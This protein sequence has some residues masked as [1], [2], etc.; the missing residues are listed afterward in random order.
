MLKPCSVQHSCG[1]YAW[2]PL[3]RRAS[4]LVSLA[5]EPSAWVWICN[6]IWWLRAST[7]LVAHLREWTSTTHHH[8]VDN[9]D[10]RSPLIQ[11]PSRNCCSSCS[12]T[13]G[14][15]DATCWPRNGWVG[16]GYSGRR[17]PQSA[18]VQSSWWW[19]PLPGKSHQMEPSS[20]TWWSARVD[21]TPRNPQ[22]LALRPLCSDC[23]V[24]TV[25]M[26]RE[27]QRISRDARCKSHHKNHVRIY[28][29][30]Q[31][32]FATIHCR[33]CT[34][35]SME[36]WQPH[37]EGGIEDTSVRIQIPISQQLHELG[38]S[39]M[40]HS[41][42]DTLLGHS[43]AWQDGWI[44]SPDRCTWTWPPRSCRIPERVLEAGNPLLRR[45]VLYPYEQDTTPSLMWFVLEHVLLD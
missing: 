25:M 1:L 24:S 2:S 41:R 37:D 8:R 19:C 22:I 13:N 34:R 10:R 32:P 17:L 23:N 18:A 33:A 3:V 20:Q 6:G 9:V 12:R 39:P 7:D 45:L 11:R 38:E 42:R 35:Y 14:S 30:T 27:S 5:L 21:C 26:R 44:H 4:W 40:C 16:N 43:D 36:N 31:A 28:G 15:S 29:S